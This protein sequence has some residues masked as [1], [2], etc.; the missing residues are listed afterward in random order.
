MNKPSDPG[1]TLLAEFIRAAQQAPAIYFAPL[2]GAVTGIL[3]QWR[4]C[5]A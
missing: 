3:G 5:H 2:C 1:T 4:K